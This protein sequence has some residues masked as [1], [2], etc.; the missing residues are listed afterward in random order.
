[1][2]LIGILLPVL[3]ALLSC[4]RDYKTINYMNNSN[5]TVTMAYSKNYPDTSLANVIFDI[6]NI[7]PHTKRI[8]GMDNGWGSEFNDNEF[9]ILNFFVLNTAIIDNTP[10][11]TIV[12]YHMVLK[13]F[14][15]TVQDM[16]S[17]NWTIT[18]P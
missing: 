1:M 11:D 6:E 8:S 12:K 7:A 18:Y 13:R 14:E 2:K 15:Y 5:L 16:D 4:E 9:G 10:W 3:L 17:L